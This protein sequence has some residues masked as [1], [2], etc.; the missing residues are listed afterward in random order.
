M[1]ILGWVN[2][3]HLRSTKDAAIL[4]GE[5][6]LAH[7]VVKAEDLNALYKE[8]TTLEEQARAYHMRFMVLSISCI[9][10]GYICMNLA[11]LLYRTLH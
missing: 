9:I 7:E 1:R 4:S 6:D 11:Y 10:L 8:V 2:A 5:E 3:H